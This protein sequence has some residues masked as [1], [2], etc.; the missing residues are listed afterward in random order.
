MTG[1][2]PLAAPPNSGP[3]GD[4]QTGEFYSV[5]APGVFIG[6]SRA[7]AVPVV[8]STVTI[9]ANS[10]VCTGAES[11]TVGPNPCT[12]TPGQPTGTFQVPSS[13]ASGAYN[14]Y[15]DETNT[16]PLPGNGPNDA[17][18]TARAL[19]GYRRVDELDRGGHATFDHLGEQCHLHRRLRRHLHRHLT[20]SPTAAL[21]ESGALPTGVT[22][23]QR[24][25]DRHPR[26]DPGGRHRR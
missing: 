8:N 15:I 9:G 12:M 14:I 6:T 26:W 2:A 13:L 11:T 10:Y 17:Y 23:G 18:Q 22:F 24:Q 21:S 5:S 7:T 25:R 19:A 16:T 20:G 4:D 3:Y 1:G